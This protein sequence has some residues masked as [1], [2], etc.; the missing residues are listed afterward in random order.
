M[1]T[2][3]NDGAA[4]RA[5]LLPALTG[6]RFFAAMAVLL[7]HYGAGF[8]DRIHAPQ[9]IRQLLHN[10][11][12]GVSLFFV[13]SGFIITY[14][15]FTET[16]TPGVIRRFYWARIARIYPV[17]LVALLLALPTL[18]A[19]LRPLDALAV[20][21]MTQAWTVPASHLGF[22]WVMQAWTLS[23]EAAF[24]LL[25]PFYWPWVR[26]LSQ[27]G[28]IALALACAV[29]IVIFAVPLV[30][31]GADTVASLGAGV[32]VPIPLFRML[33][34]TYGMA[35]C[36]LFVRWPRPISGRL[37]S[38]LELVLALA[39][40]ATLATA[41]SPP[42]KAMFT[43]LT[44]LF[45]LVTAYDKGIVSRLLSTRLM[46]LLGGAS[47]AIYILQQ[48]LRSLCAIVVHPPYDQ[49]ISP[50]ATILAAIFA[51]KFVE[52]PA[53]RLLMGLVRRQA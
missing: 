48:P 35:I 46:M 12:L 11:F 30:S 34:F 32:R 42:A 41:D 18:A 8:S 6:V 19:P 52:Q 31:P 27:G 44:G 2:A 3:T 4:H 16:L 1:Q 29:F 22:A 9:P 43:V 15:H 33:E 51:F 47:Y 13:L 36:Q 14:S 40:V 26:R 49:V 23:I 17:Y 7:F 21:T 24:Y 39:M 53:R 28:T 5:R 38:A 45:I 10:G 20:L 25:F 37:A 50:I